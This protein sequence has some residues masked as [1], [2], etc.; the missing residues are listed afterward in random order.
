MLCSVVKHLGSGRALE[1]WGRSLDCVSCF[2]LHF[3]RALQLPACFTTEQ[4]TVE[5]TL[6]VNYYHFFRDFPPEEAICTVLA[7]L[8]ES[9][10]PATNWYNSNLLQGKLKKYQTMCTRNKSVNIGD[11]MCLT[12]NGKDIMESEN[13]KILGVTIDC[14]LNFNVHISNICK[15]A[16]QR[17]GVIMRL[18]NLIPTEAK[19]HLCK[20]AILPHL[21][22]CHLA[23]HF[24][25]ASDTR[26]LER[27]QERGLRAVLTR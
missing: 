15:K 4:S 12:V 1:K 5:A 18:R 19:L 14:N 26:R 7:K 2:P 13:L 24:C 27:V 9:A 10:T 3:F 8:Q 22:N 17:I 11:K 25:R 6:F 21:T 20:A 23:W 16:S